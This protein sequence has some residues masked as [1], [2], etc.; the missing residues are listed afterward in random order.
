VG[1]SPELSRKDR[2]RNNETR[3]TGCEELIIE[4]V[5]RNGLK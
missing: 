1:R 4:K 2:K 5:K 3:R